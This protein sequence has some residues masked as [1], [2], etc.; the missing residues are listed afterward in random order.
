[1]PRK[2]VLIDFIDR[3]VATFV[4]AFVGVASVSG[5][6][7]LAGIKAAAIAGA[8]SVGKFAAVKAQAYLNTPSPKSNPPTPPGVQ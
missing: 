7:T 8:F 6:S 2:K 4:F 5:V 1:M 3:V